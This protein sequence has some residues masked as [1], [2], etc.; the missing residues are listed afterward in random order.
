MSDKSKDNRAVFIH[1][2][3]TVDEGA[4][5]GAGS[6]VWHYAHIETDTDIGNNCSFGQ[7]VYV[8][9]GV[10][11]G[12]NCRVQNNVSLYNGVELEE[13]VFCG[14]SMV[15]TN[16]LTPRARF[17]VGGIYERTRV[18]RDASIGANATVVCGHDIG[19]GCLIAAGA[20]VTREVKPFTIMQGVPARTTGYICRCGEILATWPV[21]RSASDAW[22]VQADVLPETLVCETCD[23]HYRRLLEGGLEEI[24]NHA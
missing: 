16:V 17:P 1:M 5:I 2:T 18:G 9:K 20:V 22:R 3:A 8:A 10:K 24:A 19:E 13:G 11:V 14:P 23:R 12:D 7:N 4:R 6:K 21:Q 15:F